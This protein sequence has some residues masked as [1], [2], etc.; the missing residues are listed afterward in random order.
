MAEWGRKEYKRPWPSRWHVWTWGAFFLSGVFF[1]F[2][3]WWDGYENWTAA[4]R[5]YLS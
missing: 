1:V 2:A 5:L 3:A 4:E